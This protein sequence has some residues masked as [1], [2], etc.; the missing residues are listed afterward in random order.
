M[1]RCI[2]LRCLFECPVA[3]GVGVDGSARDRF[4]GGA[5]DQPPPILEFVTLEYLHL[6]AGCR[7]GIALTSNDT[8]V[9]LTN[10]HEHARGAPKPTVVPDRLGRLFHEIDAA[11]ALAIRHGRS[12]DTDRAPEIDEKLIDLVLQHR[13][14]C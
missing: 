11:A 10:C 9:A 5:P 8:D 6:E 12:L 13:C 2:P 4:D 3:Q 7:S 14:A 1:D